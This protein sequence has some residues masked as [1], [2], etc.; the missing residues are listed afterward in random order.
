MTNAIIDNCIIPLG[1][2]SNTSGFCNKG[3]NKIKHRFKPIEDYLNII[4]NK[5][6]SISKFISW[7]IHGLGTIISIFLLFLFFFF[8]FITIITLVPIKNYQN[9]NLGYLPTYFLYL[10]TGIFLNYLII[11]HKKISENIRLFYIIPFSAAFG[12]ITGI[13]ALLKGD[14]VG[15]NLFSMIF[16]TNSIT[17]I[18]PE[19]IIFPTILFLSIV[20]WYM[21]FFSI[22]TLPENRKRKKYYQS[23]NFEKINKKIFNKTKIKFFSILFSIPF[24]ILFIIINIGLQTFSVYMTIFFFDTLLLSFWFNWI[25]NKLFIF[26]DKIE[27]KPELLDSFLSRFKRETII[28]REVDT[29]INPMYLWLCKNLYFEIEFVIYLL[30]TLIFHLLSI[31]IILN[32]NI[33]SFTDLYI[34]LVFI[35]PAFFLFVIFI[36]SF[37][38]QPFQEIALF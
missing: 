32:S 33:S 6:N 15:Y 9:Y 36:D 28:L 27:N 23:F 30:F 4:K 24:S 10:F 19:Q 26:L 29:N 5:H 17:N 21:L 1:Y 25:F 12:L 13:S 22:A 11:F 3:K 34:F 35:G 31:E 14:P 7:I 8:L 20:F 2:V 37:L 38:W 18:L 16:T